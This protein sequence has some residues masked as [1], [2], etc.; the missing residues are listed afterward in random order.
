MEY[1]NLGVF[2]P[3]D[4]L[5]TSLFAMKQSSYHGISSKKTQNKTR[6]SAW[7]LRMKQI[8]SSKWNPGA[9][10]LKITRIWLNSSRWLKGQGSQPSKQKIRV[11]CDWAWD[12]CSWWGLKV[13]ILFWRKSA[14]IRCKLRPSAGMLSRSGK[15]PCRFFASIMRWGE[16]KLI[17]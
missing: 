2:L 14:D 7:Q 10:S 15:K 6:R 4:G 3:I 13:M 8:P 12:S 5:K 16:E 11:E 9:A 1:R 17:C